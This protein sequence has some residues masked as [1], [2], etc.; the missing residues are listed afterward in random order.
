M[1]I[2][3]SLMFMVLGILEVARMIG[4]PTTEH[5]QMRMIMGMVVFAL[6]FVSF[7]LAFVF[8]ATKTPPGKNVPVHP[9]LQHKPRR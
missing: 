3:F 4:L 9:L 7:V 2:L 6:S 8:A 1:W 5:N